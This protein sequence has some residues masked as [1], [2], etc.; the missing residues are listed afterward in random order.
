MDA[1]D[2]VQFASVNLRELEG[3]LPRPL[4][5]VLEKEGYSSLNYIQVQALRLSTHSNLLIVAPTG[6]GKTEAAILP[7]LK[8]LLEER[9]QPIYALYVT[10]LR[11]LNRD[12]NLRMRDLFTSLGF[13]A[14]I[15]HGDT[16][17]SQRRKI[18]EHPPHLLITTPETLQFILVDK[19]FRG[20]LQNLRWVVIDELHELIDDK[21][22]VQL[23]LALERL[24]LASRGLK[25][26]ALSATLRDPYDALDFISGG[27]GGAVVEWGERKTYRI[28]IADI[29]KPKE[30]APSPI[31]PELYERV[32]LI[33]EEASKGGVIVFTN[34]R[35]T[36]ELLGRILSRDFGLD[37][38]VHH[39]S[40]SREE[41]EEAEALFKQGKVKA[42]VATSSLELGVDIGYARLVFQFGSPR[43]AV[44]LVQRVG[45]AGHRLDVVS[46]GIIIPL[47]VEDA[48]ESA[49]IARRAVQGKLESLDTFTSPLDVLAHQI[50]GLL[51]EFREVRIDWVYAIVTRAK[52]YRE[53]SYSTL[54]DLLRFMDSIGIARLDG[55]NLR[56]GRRT[57]SYYYSAASMIPDNPSFDVEDIASRRRIGHLDYSFASM[58]DRDKVIILAGRAWKIEDVDIE[59]NK[60]YVTEYTGELGEPPVWTGTMLP[61]EWRVAREVGSLYRR[62]SELL[63]KGRDQELLAKYG[64]PSSVAAELKGI[65]ERQLK[66]GIIP[67]EHN[68]VVE[69]QRQGGKTIAVLHTYLGTKGNNLLALLLAYAVR[70]FYG[71][72][73]RYYS[74]PY[75]V[76]IYVASDLSPERIEAVIRDG[77]PWALERLRD[78]VRESNA[79]MLELLHV[80]TRMGV[81]DRGKG[82]IESGYLSILNKK[83]KDTPVDVEA[84]NS[85]M[86]EHFNLG[87]VERLVESVRE[88]KRKVHVFSVT[89][90]SPLA[91]LIFEKPFVKTG[92][93]SAGLPVSSVVT[94]VLKRLENTQVLL[95]CMHCSE[96]SAELRVGD[97]KSVK[98]CPRCGSR[99]LA[100]LRPYEAEN[101]K[102]IKKWRKGAKLTPEEEKFVEKARQTASLFVSYGYLA[103]LA[104]AGHGVGPST[105]KAILSKSRDVD[106]LV[107][108]VLLAEANYTRTRKYWED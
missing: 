84:I 18:A 108:N 107:K 38:R 70:G 29:A 33:A 27:R 100:V 83:L 102:A 12:I 4:L 7:I 81:I 82:K 67:T 92:V 34:T 35:D 36:A 65:I 78:A 71:V 72:S 51:L 85:C 103:V 90:L 50:A 14:E 16:P 55:D 6:S 5:E 77:L 23:T 73:A 15:R 2:V 98:A 10:P 64:I 1:G 20:Y 9:G 62:L 58:I 86:V 66:L 48:V 49:V 52:P 13:A 45:R 105:A 19:R 32:K 69:V 68:L 30:G 101:L 91:Q 56:M 57:I 11:A 8:G 46:E 22:G 106:S 43:Q 63:P 24:R 87:G 96:W 26:I 21:R 76:L 59:R 53:L 79:Y 89:E 40:L 17:L 42:I 54:L 41:R 80:A 39:G 3:K 28:T 93:V 75:R 97:A 104:L 47:G 74:D 37:V 31:P 99:A 94:A 25:V 88:G 60:V 95:F 44:K 61:V